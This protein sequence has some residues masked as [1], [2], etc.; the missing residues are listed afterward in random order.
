MIV[1]SFIGLISRY[2]YFKYVFIRFS[3]IPRTYN[4]ALNSRALSVLKIVL[5]VR[6][7]ISLYMY[8]ADDI[9]AMEKSAFMQW[10]F[11]I[12]S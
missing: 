9:F 8:G 7:L 12:L 10:V 3:R 1:V 4:E 2:V 5:V 6:C 11:F